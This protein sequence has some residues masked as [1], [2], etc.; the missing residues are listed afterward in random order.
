MQVEGPTTDP[1]LTGRVFSDQISV[2][3]C[4]SS[5]VQLRILSEAV[6]EAGYEVHTA[7]SAEDAL[8]LLNLM[9]VDIFLTGIEVGSSCYNTNATST[10]T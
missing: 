7:N 6:R 3:V 8:S 1:Q 4:E 10:I 5:Q 9:P 2:V